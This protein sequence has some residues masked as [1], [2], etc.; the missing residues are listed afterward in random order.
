MASSIAIRCGVILNPFS[1][2][3]LFISSELIF[4]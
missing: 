2:S 4:T 1:A 3:L